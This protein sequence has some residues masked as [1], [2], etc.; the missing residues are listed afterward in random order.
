MT[1]KRKNRFLFVNEDEDNNRD[2]K[3]NRISKIESSGKRYLPFVII[4]S[5][6]GVAIASV[7]IIINFYFKEPRIFT[8]EETSIIPSDI[9]KKAV[10]STESTNINIEKG[11]ENYSRGFYNNA[12]SSFNEAIESGSSDQ[13]KAIALTY[14]GIIQDDRGNYDQA[15]DY[16]L[17]ALKYDK[18]NTIAY[19]NLAISYR[20]KRDYD[21]AVKAIKKVL[22]L[23]LIISVT[24]FSLVIYCMIQVIIMR[25][26]RNMKRL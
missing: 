16:F 9:E 2:L 3:P 23:I 7:L 15:I 11:K 1:Q 10:P 14:I 13:D 8:S 22:K 21:A 5:A 12:I 18:H 26:Y 19:R 17:R 24:V 25:L 20:H 6:L 4:F